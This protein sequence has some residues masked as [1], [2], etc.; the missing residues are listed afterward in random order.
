[1]NQL[2]QQLIEDIKGFAGRPLDFVRYAFRWGRG[3]LAGQTGPDD[4]QAELLTELGR[5]LETGEKNPRFAVASGHGVGKSALVAWLI[6]WAM[7]TRPHLAGMVTANTLGQLKDK[8]WAELARWHKRAINSYW[9]K[10]TATKFFVADSPETWF[11]SAVPW[12]KE[13]SEAFAGLH[14][15]DVLVIMDE[16]S[17]IPDVIWEVAEGAMTTGG[18]FLAFGNPTRNT[19]RFRECFG[20]YKHRWTTRQVDGRTAKMVNQE[21]VQ[22]WL[23]DY[24]EDSDFFRVRVR[25]VFPRAGSCQLIPSD[26]VEA[27]M[28]R[29]A[30]PDAYRHAPRVMGVDVARFGDDQSVIALRQGLVLAKP[31]RKFRGLDTMTLAGLVAEEIEREA[32]AAVFMDAGGVGGG[33]V[34]RLHQLGFRQVI[35]VDFGGAANNPGLYFNK[36]TEMWCLLR[37]WLK[38]PAVLPED[39]ELLA[40]LTGPEY[41]FTGDRGQIFLEKKKDLKKRGLASPDCADAL[42]LTFAQPVGLL[43]GPGLTYAS[44]DF[45]LWAPGGAA[46]LPR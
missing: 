38:G 8:T 22:E 41:G 44:D 30:S 4:W 27:A 34:D 11:V 19:G 43:A 32:P 33:P 40:D 20:R 21:Q 23:D 7:S 36:R 15:R 28:G 35:P 6:L 3:D 18:F 37:D 17:A 45:N 2:E 31:L 14:A 46:G 10:W 25:G 12:S 24:G 9:F 39:P 26:L 16:A 5:Q 42:A 1:M 29:K 13:N